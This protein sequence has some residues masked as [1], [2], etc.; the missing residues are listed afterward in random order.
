M[1]RNLPRREISFIMGHMDKKQRDRN[2]LN[3]ELLLK[4]MLAVALVLSIS[5]ILRRRNIHLED[6]NTTLAQEKTAAP[7]ASATATPAPAVSYFQIVSEKGSFSYE[8]DNATGFVSSWTAYSQDGAITPTLSY[9]QAQIEVASGGSTRESS[10]LSLGGLHFPVD[11]EV[12]VSF[13]ASATADSEIRVMTFDGS[14][15][16]SVADQT[17][18]ITGQEQNYSFS[19]TSPSEIPDGIVTIYYGGS[20]DY[21]S[22]TFRNIRIL[23]SSMDESVRVNQA[24]YVSANRKE[25]TFS[26]AS[27]DFFDV[28]E[29]GT[30]NV[31][32]TGAIVSRGA[33][34]FSGETTGIGDFS[35][36][37]TEGS[38]YIR[39]QTGQISPVF[40]IAADPYAALSQDLL[41]FFV[42]Q[43]CGMDL[44]SATA[45]ALAHAA[46]HSAPALLYGT[47]S[48]ADVHGGW[49]DAGDF[50]RYV[51]TGA[52]A[53][54]D[55]MMA[56]MYAPSLWSDDTAS[57]DAG[58]GTADIL[59]EVRYELEWMLRM[60]TSDGSVYARATA[61]FFP[62]DFLNPADDDS[63]IYV[64]PA[65]TS[66][67][68]SFAG[69]MAT[70]S[71]V[72]ES[73]DPA[74]SQQ[75]LEAASRAWDYLK[76]E[77]DHKYM[78]NPDEITSGNYRDASDSDNRFFASAALYAAAKDSKYLETAKQLYEADAVAAQGLSW[79]EVGE[80]GAW[81]LVSCSDLSS[82]DAAFFTLLKNGITTQADLVLSQASNG[83]GYSG[84]A[85]VGGSNL[86]EADNGIACALAGYVSADQKYWDG[87]MNHLSYLLGRNAL[88]LCFVSG[89]GTHSPTSIH[90]RLYLSLNSV[91][92]GAVVGG[93]DADREDDMTEALSDGT[94]L[95]KMYV[96][97]YRSYSTNEPSIYYNS[98]VLALVTLMR[99]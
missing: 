7:E 91:P 81:M 48:T 24:G 93:P 1:F 56:Y 98:S 17:F 70:A 13:S 58:N 94:A 37:Q 26:N 16:A 46:C 32:Y 31:V 23:P 52:K 6:R 88:N 85:Y 25:C 90:N 79:D 30:G 38:Y 80:Y 18:S 60:Q 47:E 84:V 57:P 92:A 73:I 22:L 9:D 49:H 12:S 87:A 51:K 65:D 5:V 62:G 76:S 95:A 72:Y 45:G 71:I 83:Y 67:T 55:L 34:E 96:D 43:R 82:A 69:V 11:T 86:R 8:P 66:A 78:D 29:Q 89:E 74:F 53:V 39:T 41:H 28:V 42:L 3:V 61:A 10:Y 20:G 36:L 15:G 77:Q 54:M 68:G 64:L 40:T 19:F 63:Q 14:T 75:C 2:R 4:A 99:Q 33:D 50:G 35:S 21:H 27:G 97:S 44:D 59:D